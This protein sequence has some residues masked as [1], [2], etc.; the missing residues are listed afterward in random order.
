VNNW[1][2][3]CKQHHDQ[4][5]QQEDHGKFVGCDASGRPLSA[6]HPWNQGKG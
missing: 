2:A 4:T 3:L 6:L 5:K 1:Q